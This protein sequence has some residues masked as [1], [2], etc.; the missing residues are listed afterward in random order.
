MEPSS[1]AWPLTR[2]VVARKEDSRKEVG[3]CIQER[4]RTKL[5][6]ASYI[7]GEA[8]RGEMGWKKERRRTCYTGGDHSRS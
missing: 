2:G 6:G 3:G 8:I 5:L 4:L 7:V 1:K